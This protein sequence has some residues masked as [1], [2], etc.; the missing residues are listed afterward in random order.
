MTIAAPAGGTLRIGGDF[1][2]THQNTADLSLGLARVECVGASQLLEVGG[3]DVDVQVGRLPDRNFGFEQLTIGQA[4][5]ASRVELVDLYDNLEPGFAD[6]LYL[7]GVEDV[8]GVGGK[9][10]LRILGESTLVIGDLNVFALLDPNVP[11]EMEWTSIRDLFGPGET[12]IRFDNGF[13]TLLGTF[14]LGDLN[15]DNRVAL[16]DLGILLANFGSNCAAPEDGDLNRDGEV[17]LQDLGQL[18]AVFG[19]ICS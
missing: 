18:L 7:W 4:K 11:G 15:G 17:N 3:T 19:T 2:Y 14:C 9:R 12:T 16:A 1:S 5:Q 13:I 8:G 10:G 6:A